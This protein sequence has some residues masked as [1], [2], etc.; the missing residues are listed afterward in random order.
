MQ[1]GMSAIILAAGES[2]RFW[3]LSA[4][5]HKSLFEL[6]GTAILRRTIESVE[7]LGVRD[8]VVVQSPRGVD[9]VGNPGVL[10]SDLL[11]DRYT[12]VT[13]PEPLGQ[14]DALLR[15]AD[16]VGDEFLVVQP[17]N[18]NA[19]DIGAE[20][21]A[22]LHDD[23]VAVVAGQERVDFP[24]F[25]VMEHDDGVLRSI[26]EKPKT[27]S[28]ATPLCNMGLYLFRRPLLSVL[29]ATPPG[30]YQL[31]EC[32]G[33][34]AQDKNVRVFATAHRFLPLKYPEHLWS[35]VD[36]IG[37]EFPAGRPRAL[38]ERPATVADDSGLVDVIVGARSRVGTGVRVVGGEPK[39]TVVGTD[40]VVEDDVRI[41]AGVRIGSGV[42]VRRGAVV[43]ADVPDGETV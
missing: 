25:A 37:D 32:L 15:C 27:A 34:A 40:T 41:A 10:P 22:N 1:Q 6:N 21:L 18:V 5:R 31:I 36:L 28:V 24:L 17:E 11:D 38:V 2:R 20:C 4:G 35:Y 39:T 42:T 14:G 8:I 29:R 43:Q 30:P 12:F 3:P 23:S 26:V 16:Q 13:Q 33:E 9:A 19:G 7:R